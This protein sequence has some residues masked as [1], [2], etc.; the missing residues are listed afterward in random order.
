MNSPSSTPGGN[1]GV[2]VGVLDELRRQ[3]MASAFA[4]G[5]VFQGSPEDCGSE[6]AAYLAA[7]HWGYA[8]R[9]RLDAGQRRRLDRVLA[10]YRVEADFIPRELAS[11][12][13]G[14][15]ADFASLAYRVLCGE[16]EPPA[17]SVAA[18]PGDGRHYLLRNYDWLAP[19]VFE[20]QG[21]YLPSGG[22]AF[23]AH[24][25]WANGAADG[26]NSAG[27][28]LGF[29]RAINAKKTV[30][31]SG[32][33]FAQAAR[34]LL[35][36]CATTREATDKLERLKCNG[37]WRFVVLDALGNFAVLDVFDGQVRVSS[38]G[39]RGSHGVATNHFEE[40]PFRAPDAVSGFLLGWSVERLRNIRLFLDSRPTMDFCSCERLLTSTGVACRRPG[41][42]TI[43]S[44]VYRTPEAAV[45]WHPGLVWDGRPFLRLDLGPL[46]A[47]RD[48]S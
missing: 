39:N 32:L 36:S 8:R 2:P 44:A 5:A 40:G 29:A 9:A 46:F 17:C 30:S 26:L 16:P 14:L 11:A 4:S 15:G 38:F 37:A 33:H 31:Q 19:K 41:S 13:E 24:L 1:A 25:I 48:R 23:F 7:H 35:Q 34:V 18:V 22:Y 42:G 45:S 47:L 43:W 27:L 6:L 12:A 20:R 3:G 10:V 28:A 21:L